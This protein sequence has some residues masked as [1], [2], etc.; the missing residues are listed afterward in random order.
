MVKVELI[1]G[2]SWYD[3]SIPLAINHKA[4]AQNATGVLTV[5]LA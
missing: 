1:G 4:L 3:A 5:Y 2:S